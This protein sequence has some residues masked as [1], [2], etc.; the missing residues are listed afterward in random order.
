M[1]FVDPSLLL[2]LHA[3]IAFTILKSIWISWFCIAFI[4]I[5]CQENVLYQKF[6]WLSKV[7]PEMSLKSVRSSNWSNFSPTADFESHVHLGK[8]C[9]RKNEMKNKCDVQ[10]SE[11]LT[12][13]RQT[14]FKAQKAL[15]SD[16]N[17]IYTRIQMTFIKT[18]QF[19]SLFVS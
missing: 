4:A 13:A 7:G 6:N 5:W 15:V 12:T 10:C 18:K 11:R 8:D 2:I 17:I 14:H 3:R 19:T 16:L 9:A 1:I